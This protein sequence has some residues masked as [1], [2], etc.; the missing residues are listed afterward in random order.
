MTTVALCHSDQEQNNGHQRAAVKAL[1]RR[2]RLFAHWL[3]EPKEIRKLSFFS[4]PLILLVF[5]S[6]RTS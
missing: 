5:H 3:T 6:I 1:L 4:T 2:L